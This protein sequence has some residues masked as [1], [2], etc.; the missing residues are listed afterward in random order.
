MR[1]KFWFG[2]M[3]RRGQWESG[4]FRMMQQLGSHRGV[5]VYVFSPADLHPSEGWTWGY[6]YRNGEWL[7]GRYPMPDVTYNRMFFGRGANGRML[8]RVVSR[9][10]ARYHPIFINESVPGK[11]KSFLALKQERSLTPYLAETRLLTSQSMLREFLRQHPSV[12]LKSVYGMQGRGI[13]RIDRRQNGYSVH[14]RNWQSQLSRGYFHSTASLYGFI[15]RWLSGR[16]AICQETLRLDWWHQRPA[17][18]RI[19]LQKDGTGEWQ[20]T[21]M[22]ARV[23]RLKG[24]TS[25]LHSGGVCIPADEYVK[26]CSQVAGFDPVSKLEELYVLSIKTAKCIEK[27]YGRMGELG[28]D[29]GLDDRG[30]FFILE[31]NTQPGRRILLGLKRM[32]LYRLAVER[33]I[34]YAG[35]LH[36]RRDRGIKDSTS[37]TAISG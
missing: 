16:Q 13:L 12:Y 32:D 19:L 21:G 11:W 7:R 1:T 33:P 14:A 34:L 29:I 31:C 26:A 10:R 24:L 27:A 35:Y 3:S 9:W 22:G 37:S 20:V 17:D 28:L 25:N 6:R 23:G 36:G 5:G 30:H 2:I 4:F 8:M 15:R 18:L